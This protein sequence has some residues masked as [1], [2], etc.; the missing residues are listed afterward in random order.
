MTNMTRAEWRTFA[1][2]CFEEVC[3]E[4]ESHDMQ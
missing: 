2:E 1:Q 3:A 4:E